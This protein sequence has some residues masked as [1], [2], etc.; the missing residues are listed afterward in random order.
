L[1]DDCVCQ[2][3]YYEPRHNCYFLVLEHPSFPFV[4]P[5]GEMPKIDIGEVE[6]VEVQRSI[7]PIP[8]EPVAS[9]VFR[10]LHALSEEDR[11]SVISE[12]K[13]YKNA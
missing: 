10:V 3:A 12:I 13:G 6:E 4:E 1:P 7:L 11:Q 5:C 9:D 8:R 2:H